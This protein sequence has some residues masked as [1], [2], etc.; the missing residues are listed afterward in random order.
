MARHLKPA[1]YIVFFFKGIRPAA[2][3]IGRSPGSIYKWT[4]PAIEKGTGGEI[5]RAAQHVIL[6]LA[7]KKKLD[8]T[9]EDLAFGRTVGSAK[10]R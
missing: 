4:R 3:A 1:E 2:R 7:L 9:A 8:I 6:K 5:P 10:K